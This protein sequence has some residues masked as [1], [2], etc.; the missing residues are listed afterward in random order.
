MARMFLC[1]AVAAACAGTASAA[2]LVTAVQHYQQ[3]DFVAA[4]AELGELAAIGQPEAQALFGQLLMRGEGGPADLAS[5]YG[6]L[7]AAVDNGFKQAQDQADKLRVL[8]S[9]LPPNQQQAGNDVLK[10]NGRAGL[11]ETLLPDNR[12]MN[13]CAGAE[14]NQ[15]FEDVMPEFPRA[16]RF[17]ARDSDVLVEFKVGVDGLPR[18][19]E[20]LAA[21]PQ[22]DL[23]AEPSIRA[24]LRSRLRPATVGGHPVESNFRIDIK[25]RII[26]GGT[27][28]RSAGLLALVEQANAG[29]PAAEFLLGSAA[30]VDPQ[31]FRIP[32]ANAFGLVLKSAQAGQPLSQYWISRELSAR[33]LCGKSEKAARWLLIAVES[34]APG[35]ELER[36]RQLLVAEAPV[37]ART[38]AKRLLVKVAQS[39]SE[40]AARLAIGILAT[41]PFDDVRDPA[42]AA[43]AM[44]SLK[45]DAYD[46]DP[47]TWESFAAVHAATGRYWDAIKQEERALELAREY[48]WNTAAMGER[49]AAYKAKKAWLGDLLVLPPVPD[50]GPP[51]STVESCEKTNFK[52]PC[53]E[54]RR[55]APAKPTAPAT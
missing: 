26:G 22:G 47:Q 24:V 9:K 3:A 50:P 45:A 1:G 40:F 48:R 53:L 23:F 10:R 34:G 8:L 25:F 12:D 51:P 31:E 18:E 52:P 39:N 5:G 17:N 30:L 15:P 43:K 32:F 16:A 2:E 54:I 19:P 27:L 37:E 33:S 36:A 55:A 44:D 29:S 7:L 49:L 28:W 41:T 11:H 4:R 42:T 46:K 35:A 38:E 6:W 21:F 20:I 13:F 14:G